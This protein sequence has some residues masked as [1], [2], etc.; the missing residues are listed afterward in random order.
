MTFK[1]CRR[2]GK[3][4]TKH[5]HDG[6]YYWLNDHY[7]EYPIGSTYGWGN[8]GDGGLTIYQQIDRSMGRVV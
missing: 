4:K 3:G 5:I 8:K 1:P 6:T 7:Y 2:C